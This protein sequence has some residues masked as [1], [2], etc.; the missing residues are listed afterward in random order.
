MSMCTSGRKLCI[1]NV[2]HITRI[3]IQIRW[4]HSS[5]NN[6]ATQHRCLINKWEITITGY[7]NEMTKRHFAILHKQQNPIK[8]LLWQ[9]NR[10]TD[11]TGTGNVTMWQKHS[12]KLAT[13][14]RNEQRWQLHKWM[15]AGLMSHLTHSRS[16]QERLLPSD[17]PTKIVKAPKEASSSSRGFNPT[18]T[19][20]PCHNE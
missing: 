12:A 5:L 9:N 14:R 2:T 8:F 13:W 18:R 7:E 16:L 4:P 17:D 20:P 1:Q 10:I 15:C 19:T 11:K 3:T 6:A